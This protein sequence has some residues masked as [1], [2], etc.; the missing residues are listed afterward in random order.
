MTTAIGLGELASLA[1][2]PLAEAVSPLA[3]ERCLLV[4]LTPAAAAGAAEQA[5][6]RWLRRQPCPVIGI[7]DDDASNPLQHAC[8]VIVRQRS[9]AETLLDN[10]RCSPL[11]SM[12]LV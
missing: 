10:V 9:Q 1:C 12:V 5:I 7:A 2:A 4:D 11:A 3:G 6:A 8:D